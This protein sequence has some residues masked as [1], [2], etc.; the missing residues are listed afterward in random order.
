MGSVS[1]PVKETS[2]R[3]LW[4]IY[5]LFIVGTF[6][7]TFPPLHLLFAAV[8]M[9]FFFTFQQT[10][11]GDKYTSSLVLLMAYFTRIQHLLEEQEIKQ[12]RW[13]LKTWNSFHF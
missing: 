4:C 12:L 3:L 10:A 7:G 1:I 13:L 6:K 9:Q 2:I 11:A 8:A 5:N